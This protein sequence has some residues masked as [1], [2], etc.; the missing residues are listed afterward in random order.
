MRVLAEEDE[1]DAGMTAQQFAA[2]SHEE[3]HCGNSE[4][5]WNVIIAMTIVDLRVVWRMARPVRR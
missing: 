3:E 2:S 1:A 5:L 4:R